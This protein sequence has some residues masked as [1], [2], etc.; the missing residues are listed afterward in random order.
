M[1]K[2]R[3]DPETGEFA[4]THSE[5]MLTDSYVAR[6][7]GLCGLLDESGE[8]DFKLINQ[9]RLGHLLTTVTT[10]NHETKATE[11]KSAEVVKTIR[12][13]PHS[14]LH[15]ASILARLRGIDSSARG[16]G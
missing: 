13:Q 7:G 10:T 14:L 15:A 16:P 5:K 3:I 1:P 8:V 11:D 12:V 9:K 4:L 2:W 6:G